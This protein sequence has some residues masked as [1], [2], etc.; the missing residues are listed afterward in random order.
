MDNKITDLE[1]TLALEA[2]NWKL[3]ISE[4]R[5]MLLELLCKAGAGFYN[6]HT[7]EEFLKSFGVMKTDRT[8]NKK[9]R[10]FICDT[11]YKS[12]NQKAD[13]Y[14]LIDRYRQ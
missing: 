13:I 5:L 8:P 12:S 1:I 4:G 9:G 3:K 7:E 14:F 2:L 10:A 11:V 6:S